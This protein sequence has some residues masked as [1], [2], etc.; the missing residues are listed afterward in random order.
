MSTVGTWK[1][2]KHPS[3]TFF[4]FFLL[5]HASLISTLI[6]GVSQQVWG[7]LEHMYKYLQKPTGLSG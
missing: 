6:P 3:L 1:P 7:L 2:N 5:N 4:Q